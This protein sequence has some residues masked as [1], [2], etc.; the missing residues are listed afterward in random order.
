MHH[1]PILVVDADAYSPASKAPFHIM[2]L[3]ASACAV[4]MCA[5]MF[6]LYQARMESHFECPE[7]R[8]VQG[9]TPPLH[10]MQWCAIPESLERP[11]VADGAFVRWHRSAFRYGKSGRLPL[12]LKTG[13]YREGKRFGVFKTYRVHNAQSE[14]VALEYYEDDVLKCSLRFWYNAWGVAEE[15]IGDPLYCALLE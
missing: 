9:G 8:E 13:N 3:L 14:P 4:L 2:A 7:G 5:L 12:P 15:R 1:S 10:L 6:T 11:A